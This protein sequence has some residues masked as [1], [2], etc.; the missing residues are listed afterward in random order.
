MVLTNTGSQI[1]GGKDFDGQIRVDL[2][3]DL[4][5]VTIG[6]VDILSRLSVH[7]SMY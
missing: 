5:T 7:L 2:A 4:S 1:A 3:D 6:E